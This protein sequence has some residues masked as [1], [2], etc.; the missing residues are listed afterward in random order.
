[1]RGGA[2]DR[3]ADAD[4]DVAVVGAG[5][6]GQMA[7]LAAAEAGAR[8]GVLELMD[9]AGLKVLASGGGR[10]NL[11][12]L[13]SAGE[14]QAA[15]GRQGRFTAPAFDALG[16]EA[17]RRLLERLGVETVVAEG[18]GVYPASGRAADVQA[19]LARRLEQLGVAVR[20]GEAA[21]GLWIDDGRLRGVQLAGGRR[22]GARR[23]VLACGGRS[24]PKLGGTGGG[25]ALAAQAGHEVTPLCPALVP[26]ATRERWPAR[27]AGVSVRAARVR[28][29]RRG[30]DK[31]GRTGDLLFTHRGVSGP[32]VLDLSG[33]VAELLVKGPVTLRVEL[34]AGADAAEW[35]RRLDGWRGA[36][37]RRTVLNLL[38]E[39]LP[40]S[41]CAVLC[42]LAG[43]GG[44]V[45][46]AQL[47]KAAADKLAGLLGG[48]GLTVAASEGF[49]VA[50]VTRGGVKLR[51][52]DPSALASRLLAGLYLAGELLD[53]DGPSGGYNLQWALAS[54]WLAGRSA[55]GR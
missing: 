46:A 34:A 36:S 18:G 47:A 44:E 11:S 15:F 28:I 32:A 3:A 22:V 31:A 23:V 8:V 52:V 38:D 20:L 41:L 24:W 17:L 21:G 16:P 30:E 55:A 14:F 26:L 54:G 39:H 6:A 49:D 43:A 51:Q 1:M 50:F 53:L 27:L 25:Y 45:P 33:R 9:R 2:A 12:R 29:D 37:G 48:L 19:A 7:A 10:C 40:R 35:A 42:E 5:A 13:V 4:T